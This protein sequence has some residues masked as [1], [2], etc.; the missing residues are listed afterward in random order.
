M[1]VT[2]AIHLPFHLNESAQVNSLRWNILYKQ[3][4]GSFENQ[5]GVFKCKD[6]FNDVVALKMGLKFIVHGF[7]NSRIK[8]NEEGMYIL[9]TNLTTPKELLNNIKL[10]SSEAERCGYPNIPVSEENK[11][12]VLFIDNRYLESTYI[13]SWLT[14]IIRIAHCGKAYETYEEFSNNCPTKDIDNPMGK[15]QNIA[16]EQSFKQPTDGWFYLGKKYNEG[17][18][19]ANAQGYAYAIHNNGVADWQGKLALGL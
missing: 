7:D 9:L 15:Y 11:D 8:L 1:Q 13:I 16:F 18:I 2:K 5:S 10:I 6:Y 17:V 3:K 12:L 14:Y 19:A 4:D